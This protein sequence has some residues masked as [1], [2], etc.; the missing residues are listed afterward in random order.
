MCTYTILIVRVCLRLADTQ[1]IQMVKF[2]GITVRCVHTRS[3]EHELLSYMTL[4]VH[5]Q[6]HY[7]FL[8]EGHV[9]EDS[10]EAVYIEAE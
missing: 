8:H 2:N 6:C 9:L 10:L 4:Y 5:S 1:G 7:Q 3:Q